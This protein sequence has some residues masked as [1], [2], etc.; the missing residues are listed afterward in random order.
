MSLAACGGGGSGS[1]SLTPVTPGTVP[2]A[3]ANITL[4]VPKLAASNIG[5]P[6][7]STTSANGR[8]TPKYISPASDKLTF[9]LDGTPVVTDGLV[10][11]YIDAGPNHDGVIPLA[12]GQGS[13]HLGYANDPSKAY[14][15]V[16]AAFTVTPGNHK[17]GVVN[18]SGNPA[19]VLSEGERTYAFR[20]GD[21]NFS[22]QP[23]SLRGVVATGYIEC[24]TKDQ[25]ADPL[26]HCLEYA[27]WNSGG[28]Y[29]TFTAVAADYNGFPIVDQGL[30]YLNGTITVAESPNDS[31]N[32][33]VTISGAG[34][35]ST[36][37]SAITGPS[38][39][40]VTGSDFAYGQPFYATCAK[41]GTAHLQLSLNASA[42]VHPE[43]S[44]DTDPLTKFPTIALTGGLLPLGLNNATTPAPRVTNVAVTCTST[45]TIIIQ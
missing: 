13:V 12:N 38:G 10:E 34:P 3:H 6:A 30:P 17:I 18:L 43:G 39:G 37:G 21:N 14:F 32:N 23:L 41:V 33:I 5:T 24:A 9:I 44:P 16:T 11:H 45:G 7:T 27:N 1:S 19:Y 8:R 2:N 40:W 26:G 29:Y 31:P 15:T 4:Q 42:P 25:N 35:W 28:S 36:P 20:P 22:S